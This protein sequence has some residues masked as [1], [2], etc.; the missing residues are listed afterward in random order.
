MPILQK[1]EKNKEDGKKRKKEKKTNKQCQKNKP[2]LKQGTSAQGH[3]M[4]LTYDM[5]E[6]KTKT[7]LFCLSGITASPGGIG[8]W[9]NY[10]RVSVTHQSISST[11]RHRAPPSPQLKDRRT[12]SKWTQA[13]RRGDT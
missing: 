1:R 3:V 2:S 9:R 13:E 6:V 7:Y 10:H 5:M 12:G 8:V 11:G 4:I